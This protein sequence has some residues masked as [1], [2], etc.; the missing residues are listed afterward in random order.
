MEFEIEGTPHRGFAS[1]QVAAKTP[2]DATNIET[3]AAGERISTDASQT[4]SLEDRFSPE[5]IWDNLGMA[6]KKILI[7]RAFSELGYSFDDTV[8]YTALR[9][10]DFPS[11]EKQSAVQKILGILIDEVRPNLD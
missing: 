5:W 9:W 4:E 7:E 1:D 3:D 2:E 8:D 6:Q 10:K 11:G